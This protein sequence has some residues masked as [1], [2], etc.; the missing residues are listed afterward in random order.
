MASVLGWGIFVVVLLGLAWQ[1]VVHRRLYHA[2]HLRTFAYGQWLFTLAA[3]TLAVAVGA[4]M[5]LGSA[6]GRSWTAESAT[7]LVQVYLCATIAGLLGLV[8][9]WTAGQWHRLYREYYD[10]RS[11]VTGI[12][13]PPAEELARW[14]RVHLTGHVPDDA[15]VLHTPSWAPCWAGGLAGVV[16]LFGPLATVLF[17][18]GVSETLTGAQDSELLILTPLVWALVAAFTACGAVMLAYS[19]SCIRSCKIPSSS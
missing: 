5:S 6:V 4:G 18:G 2:T 3:V 9:L 14:W 19:M 16:L 8:C 15:E 1:A 13:L 10:W 11:V 17:L 12:D 7:A